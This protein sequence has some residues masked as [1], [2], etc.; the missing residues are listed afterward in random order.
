MATYVITDVEITDPGM[1]AEFRERLDPTVAAYGGTFVVRDEDIM[2]VQGDW[3]PSRIAM[4]EFPNLDAANSWV[5]SSEFGAIRKILD[6]SSNT[7]I[8]IADGV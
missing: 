6:K 4:I 3:N 7:N 8:V 5:N 1:F 2:V